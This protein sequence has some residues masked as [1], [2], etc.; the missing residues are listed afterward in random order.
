VVKE[1]QAY[2]PD[3]AKMD[4]YLRK[5]NL[6]RLLEARLPQAMERAKRLCSIPEDERVCYSEVF[7]LLELLETLGAERQPPE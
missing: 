1:L 3:Y 6:C 2:L 7:K 5:N 4:E